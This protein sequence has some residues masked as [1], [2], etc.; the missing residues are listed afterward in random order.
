M[1]KRFSPLDPDSFLPGHT[2]AYAG[3]RTGGRD[4][5]RIA[6]CACRN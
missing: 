3:L 1:A 2:M 4:D 5:D 6:E